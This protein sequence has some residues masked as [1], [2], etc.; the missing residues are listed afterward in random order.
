MVMGEVILRRIEELLLGDTLEPRPTLAICDPVVLSVDWGHSSVV[1]GQVC[2]GEPGRRRVMKAVA[3]GGH[4][5][6][7]VPGSPLAIRFHNVA[8]TGSCG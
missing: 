6:P 1:R 2:R 4:G 5:D 8:G 3:P 7:N